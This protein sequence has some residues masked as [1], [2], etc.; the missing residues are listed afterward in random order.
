MTKHAPIVNG[1]PHLLHGGDYNPEQW[2]DTPEVWDEDVRLMRAAHVN[3]ASIGIFSWAGLEREDGRYTFDWM[4]RVVE[5]LA[6]GGIGFVLATPGGAKPA[7]MAQKYPET[8][9]VNAER[10]RLLWGERHNHCFTSP[11]FRRKCR[12]MNRRLA[13]RYG[14]H[15]GLAMWHVNNEYNGDC[16]C[17]LCQAAFRNWLRHRYGN[18]LHRLNHAWWTTF[19][20]HTYTD[21]DQIESPSPLGERSV[22]GL[23]LDWKRFATDQTVNCFRDESAPLRELAPGVPVTTNLMGEFFGLDYYKLAQACD[24]V[25]WD[26]Y[27]SYHDRE[28]DLVT[29]PEYSFTHDQRRAMLGKP[30]ILMESAPAQQNYKAVCKLKRPG[31]H[32]LD[33]L[34]AVAHGSDSVMYFQWRKSRGAIEKF[35]GAV[36]DHHGGERTRV[37]QDV[38]DLG[39]TLSKLGGVVGTATDARAAIVFDYENHWALEGAL[40]MINPKKGYYET[41]LEQHRP[42]WNLGVATDVIDSVG[43]DFGK[44][45]LLVAPMLYMLRP[46]VAE[47]V[48]AFVANGGTLVTTYLTG[49]VDETDLCF[50]SGFPGPL[51]K[52]C[53]VWAEETD[54][55]YDDESAV[56]VASDGNALGLT[57]TYAARQLCDLIHA[58]G[59]EVLATYGSQ[60][61]AGRPAVTVNRFGK[62]KAYYVAS[63][64]DDRFHRDFY[65]ALVRELKLPR[66]LGSALPPGVTAQVRSDGL[67]DYVFVFSFSRAAH[68]VSLGDTVYT[69]AISGEPVAATLPLPA[70]GVRVLSRRHAAGCGVV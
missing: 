3:V 22:H 41:C 61:Y 14:H 16:H 56:V 70:Y 13:E 37:F 15:P 10:R 48:E 1:F 31:M 68:D 6:A 24:V 5:K 66:A 47:R 62:G 25:S 63:R 26:A 44:Y 33:A 50:L 42:L 34:Q 30:F 49:L 36:V 23:V 27:P 35:H 7:W 32:R 53:G 20:S 57:G 65:S 2:V 8:L 18:D 67:R 46:G 55:L 29:G 11:A 40:G 4:D 28:T 51:R 21:W 52:V 59:A 69:D 45:D 39:A 43:Y 17:D 64:N 38:A 9:R 12:E 60:F 58:E 54:A 19:W